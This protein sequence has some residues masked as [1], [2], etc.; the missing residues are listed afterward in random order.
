MKKTQILDTA[1]DL[2]INKGFGAVSM[3]FVANEANVSKVTLYAHFENKN[4]LFKSAIG[5][6]QEKYQIETPKLSVGVAKNKSELI[7]HVKTYINDA[8]YFYCDEYV[9]KLYRLL[10]RE[11]NQFPEIFELIFGNQMGNMTSGLSNYLVSYAKSQ[12]INTDKCYILACHILDLLRG[13]TL[14]TKLVQNPQKLYFVENPEITI[15]E[16]NNVSELLINK[17]LIFN[18]GTS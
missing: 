7:F 8:F 6:Y 1:S 9:V 5:Y 4:N 18:E 11:I 14:W 17:Y 15:A 3:D 13:A 16:I 10:I 2:F 12:R